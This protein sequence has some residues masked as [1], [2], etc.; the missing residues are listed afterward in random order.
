MELVFIFSTKHQMHMRLAK[1]SVARSKTTKTRKMYAG[2][3]PEKRNLYLT[4]EFRRAAKRSWFF[5]QL[6]K[7]GLNPLSQIG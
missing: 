1:E 4:M 2:T 6:R 7:K 3:R 5:T